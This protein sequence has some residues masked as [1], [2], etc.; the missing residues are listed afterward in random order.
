MDI[1]IKNGCFEINGKRQF[2]I[3][4]E[5]Q[6]F[7]LKK[8]NWQT[9]IAR[10]KE[11]NCNT[12]STYVPW[13]WHEYKK[14][15]FDFDGRTHPSRDLKSFLEIVEKN[16]LNLIIKIGPHIHA[17]FLNGGIP[18]WLFTEHP[19][20][21][22]LDNKGRPTKDY[23]FYPPITYLHPVYM[24]YVYRWYKEVI[25]NLLAYNNIIMWQVDNETSYSISFFDYAK[26]QVFNGDYNPFIVKDGLY[27]KFLAEKFQNI[28]VLNKRYNENNKTFSKVKPPVKEPEDNNEYFK[29]MDWI[30]FRERLVALY[31]RRLIEMMYNLGCKGPFVINDPLLGYATSWPTIYSIVKDSRWEVI[32]GYT[33]Y[34]GSVE[35]ETISTH[36][37]KI[38][39]T[40]ASGTPVVGNTEL[41]ASN[42]YF[43]P[44][45]KQD[46]SDYNLMWKIAIGSGVNIVNYYWFADGYNF[47]RYEYFLPELDFNSPVDRRGNKR[48]HF[49]LIKKIGEFLNRYP[50]IVETK[51]VYDLTLGFY[52]PYARASKFNNRQGIGEFELISSSKFVGSFIDLLAVCN[53]NFQLLSLETQFE[54]L[55]RSKRLV[56]LC[57]KFLSKDI[58]RRLLNFV[59]GGG[60]LV[61]IQHVP[62]QDERL[63]RCR[64]L[65]DALNIKGTKSI[66]KPAG[67]FETNK[68]Q[69]KN[70]YFPVYSDVEVYNFDD[71]DG[72]EVDLRLHKTNSSKPLRAETDAAQICGFTKSVGE[73]KISV[74]GFIP[75]VFLDISRKFA[76]DYFNKKSIDK[77]FIFERRKKD[78]SLFTIC[79][80][81]RQEKRV[82][83][84]KKEFCIPPR[85]AIFVVIDK[86]SKRG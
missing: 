86:K 58:Q 50:E 59:L 55:I 51:P 44:H 75:R 18:S 74:I 81:Y 82:R 11:S 45:W 1:K 13:N 34:G 22:C 30:E 78:F 28:D 79:N 14:G 83:I 72:I 61:L 73:G 57:Y 46:N 19:E 66:L 35:E 9:I 12:L 60:N 40:Y 69:Y 8:K 54:K 42:A 76:R 71:K 10:L 6:Y 33:Y 80:F 47:N 29:V 52:H 16:Q 84:R 56:V 67:I 7:R 26:H 24:E 31:I 23:A 5:V 41:Q 70:Y 39:Y 4:G 48:G 62:R 21:L 17:E 27:Q 38:G 65:W 85:D 49:G 64:I 37:S 20:I 68:V 63:K 3:S 15:Q 32:I 36:L 43:L 53:I 77:I 2:I 25:K